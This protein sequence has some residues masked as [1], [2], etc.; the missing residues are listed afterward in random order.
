MK[1]RRGK[2]DL[3]GLDELD[4]HPAQRLLKLYK[5]RGVPVKLA[6]SRWSRDKVMDALRRGAHKSCQGHIDFLNEEFLD[7]IQKGQ[8]VI[9]PASVALELEGLRLSPPGVVEQRDRR[10]R[11]ICDY[12]WSQVNEDTLPL[13]ALESMQFGH[14][15]ERILREILL[16]NPAHGP[17]HLNKT[18][19]S[20]GFYREDLCPGDA[21]K[22]G[23]VYPTATSS[24]SLVAI[25]LVLPM[26][27]K[28]SPPA[29]STATET[30]ADLANKRLRD[31]SYVPKRHALDD[32][33]LE[34]DDDDTATTADMTDLEETA[35]DS[36]TE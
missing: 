17:V 18:D 31:S 26:G 27:W 9:L 35:S 14:A 28:N 3:S 34:M 2:G 8:W 30:I 29:F 19:L 24:Q 5:H 32:L 16:A 25:P 15:L 36:D 6:T 12:T 20:D 1:K 4:G 10:P 21:P 7:M 13:V 22:L 11:W 23:V 33:A